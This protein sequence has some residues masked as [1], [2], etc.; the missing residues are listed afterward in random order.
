MDDFVFPVKD[1]LINSEQPSYIDNVPTAIKDTL[2]VKIKEIDTETAQKINIIND[3]ANEK[4]KIYVDEF[5][6]TYRSMVN[7]LKILYES[8]NKSGTI[9]IKG[10]YNN[11][12]P[13]YDYFTPR[14][15]ESWKKFNPIKFDAIKFICKDLNSKGYKC[16][17][18]DVS[19]WKDD[20]DDY[21]NSK[22]YSG[23]EDLIVKFNF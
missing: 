9:K 7:Q 16:E 8:D 23:G 17:V 13:G 21:Y 22:C 10:N 5:T 19:E 11:G 14:N 15:V 3:E 6:A 18:Y 4:K 2:A 1:K 20:Y 12:K